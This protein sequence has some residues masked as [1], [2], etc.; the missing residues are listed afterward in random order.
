MFDDDD[1]DDDMSRTSRAS[2]RRGSK[3]ASIFAQCASQISDYF[4]L[5]NTTSSRGKICRLPQLRFRLNQ[6]LRPAATSCQTAA[7]VGP[8]MRPGHRPRDE[9]VF[10]PEFLDGDFA[11]SHRHDYWRKIKWLY[12]PRIAQVMSRDPFDCIWRYFH[13]T[14]RPT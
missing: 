5:V 4:C 10:R 9:G 1:D 13:N 3:T 8:S 6:S 12:E 2:M 7:S 14:V 11:S